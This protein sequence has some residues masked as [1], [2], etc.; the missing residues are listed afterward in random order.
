[1]SAYR[2]VLRGIF[3]GRAIACALVWTAGPRVMPL[4][5]SLLDL[6]APV[7]SDTEAAGAGQGGTA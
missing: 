4:P 5:D 7:A 6:H 1:M 3:P 2:A